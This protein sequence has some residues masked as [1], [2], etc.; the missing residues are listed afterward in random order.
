MKKITILL[1]FAFG[2]GQDYSLQ[3]DGEEDY[4]DLN[5]YFSLTD[6]FSIEIKFIPSSNGD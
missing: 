4:V 5:Q 2:F 6:N 3:F 1:L